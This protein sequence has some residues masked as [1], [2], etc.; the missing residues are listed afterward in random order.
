MS[1]LIAWALSVDWAL[2][3]TQ[4]Q[5]LLNEADNDAV[6]GV[7]YLGVVHLIDGLQDA[8]VTDRLVSVEQVFGDE[9]AAM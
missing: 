7:L 1:R 8:V 5:Y 4:K 9:R 3:R 6:N 2:L